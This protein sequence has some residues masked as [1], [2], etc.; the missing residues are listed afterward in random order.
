MFWIIFDLLDT[1]S[2]LGRYLHAIGH[3]E[4][5]VMFSGVDAKMIQCLIFVMMGVM[6][7]VARR[8]VPRQLLGDQ[9]D[10]RPST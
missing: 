5:G 3:N 9:P 6:C 8:H 7:A 4:N 2:T 1:R 10:H